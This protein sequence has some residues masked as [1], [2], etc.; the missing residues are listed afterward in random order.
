MRLLVVQP[1]VLCKKV[2]IHRFC[3]NIHLVKVNISYT[4]KAYVIGEVQISEI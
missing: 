3:V 1:V 2:K 4:M